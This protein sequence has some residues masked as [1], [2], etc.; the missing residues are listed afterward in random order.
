MG[1]SSTSVHLPNTALFKVNSKWIMKIICSSDPYLH[2]NIP[3]VFAAGE[4]HDKRFRQAIVSAGFAVWRPWKPRSI[5]RTLSRTRPGWNRD[6][7]PFRTCP[8]SIS[9]ANESIMPSTA[10]KRMECRCC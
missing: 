1:C 2:T 7:I 5:Y 9:T 3:G 8:I 10:I 6:S 4:V